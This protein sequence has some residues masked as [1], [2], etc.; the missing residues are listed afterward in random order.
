MLMRLSEK[1][2]KE[3]KSRVEKIF[4]KK[5]DRLLTESE[6]KY[7]LEHFTA[8]GPLNYDALTKEMEPES[9]YR[10]KRIKVYYTGR[11][12]KGRPFLEAKI[13]DTVSRFFIHHTIPLRWVGMGIMNTEELERLRD[14]VKIYSS[15]APHVYHSA[16]LYYTCVSGIWPVMIVPLMMAKVR[17][18]DFSTAIEYARLMNPGMTAKVDM[19]FLEGI[20]KKLLEVPI[21]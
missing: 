10:A 16:F 2:Y 20:W 8:L 21:G 11:T 14:S 5:T 18:V 1:E 15:I 9:Y 17:G 12:P 19:V 7:A 13:P 3:T 4:E 6:F